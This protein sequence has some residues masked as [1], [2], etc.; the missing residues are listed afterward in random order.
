MLKSKSW[1][2]RNNKKYKMFEKCDDKNWYI[3]TKCNKNTTER[4]VN[5]LHDVISKRKEEKKITK[6]WIITLICLRFQLY[7]IQQAPRPSKATK[8]CYF[9][10]YCAPKV[11]FFLLINLSWHFLKVKLACDFLFFLH[12]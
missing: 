10:F 11:H 5:P 1:I 12:K 9:T 7:A 2:L 4:D 8:F 3:N 6:K